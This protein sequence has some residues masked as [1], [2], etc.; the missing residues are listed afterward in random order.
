[1]SH[2]ALAMPVFRPLRE[3]ERR[4]ISQFDYL[5]QEMSRTLADMGHGGGA[6]SGQPLSD[7]FSVS[8]HR[9]T[10]FSLASCI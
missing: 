7:P 5:L 8:I 6:G 4:D 10:L 2:L 1:M 9:S 3:H